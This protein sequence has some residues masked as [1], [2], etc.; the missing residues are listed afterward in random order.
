MLSKAGIRRQ[1]NGLPGAP[2]YE[3]DSEVCLSD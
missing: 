2:R 3:D 1:R